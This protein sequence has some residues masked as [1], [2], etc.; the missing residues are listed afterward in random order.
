MAEREPQFETTE[1]NV[2]MGPQHPATHGVFRMVVAVDGE[3]IVDVV[4]HIGYLHRGSEKLAEN[5]QYHQITPLFDRMAYPAALNNEL[6][7]C[8]AVDRAMGH[9]VPERAQYIRV[10]MAELNRI[11]SHFLFLSAIGL[12][13][14]AMTPGLYSFRGRERLMEFFCAA[15]GARML[16]NYIQVGGVR[17]DLHDGWKEQLSKI[18]DQVSFDIDEV[19]RLL[20]FNEVFVART[21]GVGVISSDTV[22]EYGMLGPILRGSGLAYDVRKAEPYQVYDRLAFDIPTGQKGDCWDR[23]YVRL[24]ETRQ[25]IRIVRQAMQQIPEGPVQALTRPFGMRVP[26][27]EVYARAENPTGE[28]GVYLVSDGS[29]KPY[30]LKVR[31]PSFC[32][33]MGL[34]L[35]LTDSYVA[36]AIVILGTIDI[37]LGEVDR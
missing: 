37:V 20:T 13:S 11:A 1:I 32:N 29:D 31:P 15:A 30:R 4:P 28:I 36:D 2:N 26:K 18:L 16:P 34:R 9:V 22:I 3:R 19:D 6:V 23:Y 5:L 8:M 33:L 12:D 21:R 24:E 17:E 14:G 7:Y 35:M 25:S 10:I 27:G